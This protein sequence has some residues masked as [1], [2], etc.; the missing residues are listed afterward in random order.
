[1]VDCTFFAL[2]A[3]TQHQHVVYD[4]VP[5]ACHDR[6]AA[7]SVGG[8]AVKEMGSGGNGS[9]VGGLLVHA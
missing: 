6:L 1:M 2:V 3:S 4:I 8:N 7:C 5:P 9:T